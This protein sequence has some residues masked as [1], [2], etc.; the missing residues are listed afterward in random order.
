MSYSLSRSLIRNQRG[1]VDWK[2]DVA[3]LGVAGA[4]TGIPSNQ[5]FLLIT[6]SF[7][8]S[9]PRCFSFAEGPASALAVGLACASAGGLLLYAKRSILE[10]EDN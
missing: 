4:L 8:V 5:L 2:N 6:A 3:G 7:A 9:C 10:E 1:V